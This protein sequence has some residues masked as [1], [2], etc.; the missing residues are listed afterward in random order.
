MSGLRRVPRR[1]DRRDTGETLVEIVLT[2]VIIG[3]AVTALI[4]ALA[5]T[6]T[7]ST[8]NRSTVDADT[9]MRNFAEAIKD[10][11]FGCV[12]GAPIVVDYTPP[13]GFGATITPVNALC[14]AVTATTRLTLDVD[15]PSG[16]HQRMEIVVRT[17]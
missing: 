12:E 11:A 2:V 14:P 13:D 17:P 5:T 16:V 6:A 15:G 4:S 7:A 8:T 3:V 9:I 10:T 1:N